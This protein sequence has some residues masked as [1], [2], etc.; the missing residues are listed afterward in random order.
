MSRWEGPIELI[1]KLVNEI[2]SERRLDLPWIGGLSD[3]K[4]GMVTTA[5]EGESGSGR[6]VV[7][8]SENIGGSYTGILGMERH[9]H[10]GLRVKAVNIPDHFARGES[11]SIESAGKG[12]SANQYGTS[13]DCE[14]LFCRFG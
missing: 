6:V 12:S 3:L 1:I 14:S 5:L 8:N 9:Q 4:M 10:H 2:A 7:L 11:R 13:S